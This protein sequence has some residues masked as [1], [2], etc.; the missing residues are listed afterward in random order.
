MLHSTAN[1][2]SPTNRE[3]RLF[4]EQTWAH[5][6]W[7]RCLWGNCSHIYYSLLC[8]I[9]QET[10]Y[11]VFCNGYPS[12]RQTILNKLENIPSKS[13]ACNYSIYHYTEYY[14]TCENSTPDYYLFKRY[15][16]LFEPIHYCAVILTLVNESYKTMLNPYL[17]E[18]KLTSLTAGA[19]SAPLLP[20]NHLWLKSWKH[21]YMLNKKIDI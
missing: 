16:L 2:N 5:F 11:A 8:F 17:T 3:Q 12:N 1:R 13:P 4:Y 19:L 21:K 9:I 15:F 20:S 6:L 10:Q 7:W 18:K 14:Y